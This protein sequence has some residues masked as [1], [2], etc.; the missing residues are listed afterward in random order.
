MSSKVFFTNTIT[1]SSALGLLT[2]LIDSEKIELSQ[3]LPIKIHPGAIGNNAYIKPEYYSD[4]ISYLN[5]FSISP[6]FIET[7]M[8]SET[9]DGKEKEFEQHGFNQIPFEIADGKTGDEHQEA[10]IEN[11][12]HFHT[13]LIAKKLADANQVLVVSHFK[14]HGMSGFGG[15]IKM[16]GIGFASGVGKSLVHSNYNSLSDYQPLDWDNSRLS[17]NKNEFNIQDWNPQV[18]S[19]GVKFQERIAEYA[20]AASKNKKH[21]Y[22][23]FAMN[24]ASD[25]DCDGEEMKFIYP[26][27][28]IFASTDPVAIDKAV[29]DMLSKREGKVPFAGSEIFTYAES[30]GLGSTTYEL[31]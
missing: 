7:C 18:V 17:S 3:N 21:I 23:T 6:H 27:L 22:I 8:G 4:I 13:C 24:F 31:A 14:G 30:I 10:A 19:T 16:L 20:L 1:S 12:K 2:K 15:A 11:G 28:G 29:F 25:C 26:D 5:S 9:S